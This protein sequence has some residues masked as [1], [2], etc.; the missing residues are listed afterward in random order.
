MNDSIIT[1]Y[2]SIAS[3]H[4]LLYEVAPM[5]NDMDFPIFGAFYCMLLEEWCLIHEKNITDVI[6]QIS[7]II[8]SVNSEMGTYCDGASFIKSERNLSS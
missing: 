4:A 1:M 8:N 3:I 7:R 2:P 5:T 6:S